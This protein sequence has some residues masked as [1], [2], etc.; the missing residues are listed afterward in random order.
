VIALRAQLEIANSRARKER[1]DAQLEIER[2]R[3]QF[4]QQMRGDV[5]SMKQELERE[6]RR[7]KEMERSLKQRDIELSTL[8]KRQHA[9]DALRV[10]ERMARSSVTLNASVLAAS[11]IAVA[12]SPQTNAS[13][14][15]GSPKTAKRGADNQRMARLF[16]GRS[17]RK[18]AAAAAAAQTLG[19]STSSVSAQ[20]AATS[21]PSTPATAAAQAAAVTSAA[22]AAVVSAASE[23]SGI[24]AT[25]FAENVKSFCAFFE[26]RVPTFPLNDDTYVLTDRL[27]AKTVQLVAVRDRVVLSLAR[28]RA[29][30]ASMVHAAI[31]MDEARIAIMGD[32]AELYKIDGHDAPRRLTP[33]L[34]RLVTSVHSDARMP[35]DLARAAQLFD[36]SESSL[37]FEL[38]ALFDRIRVR[39]AV[40]RTRNVPST[41]AA[42]LLGIDPT[43]LVRLQHSGSG[44]G[45]GGVS[46]GGAGGNVTGGGGGG[47]GDLVSMNSSGGSVVDSAPTASL[48]GSGS[49][50]GSSGGSG[51]G[52]AGDDLLGGVPLAEREDER[53]LMEDIDTFMTVFSDS[54]DGMMVDV[55]RVH[56]QL[57]SPAQQAIATPVLTRARAIMDYRPNIDAQQLP[58][59]PLTSLLR[60]PYGEQHFRWLLFTEQC[61]ESLLFWLDV[62]RVREL[63]VAGTDAA[64]MRANLVDIYRTYIVQGASY[65][66]NISSPVRRKLMMVFDAALRASLRQMRR[67]PRQASSDTP[68][69]RDESPSFARRPGRP[70]VTLDDTSPHSFASLN[71]FESADTEQSSGHAVRKTPSSDS[72]GGSSSDLFGALDDDIDDDDDD[73]DEQQ[74][75]R[76]PSHGIDDAAKSS[77]NEETLDDE[78]TSLDVSFLKQ[79]DRPPADAPPTA[80]SMPTDEEP[81]WLTKL[82]IASSQA[83]ITDDGDVKYPCQRCGRVF[84]LPARLA[85]HVCMA[86]AANETP[87]TTP[88]RPSAKAANSASAAA[89]VAAPA[90]VSAAAA[91]VHTGAGLDEPLVILER[92]TSAVSLQERAIPRAFV[93]R[94]TRLQGTPGVTI[95]RRRVRRNSKTGARPPARVGDSPLGASPVAAA[96]VAAAAAAAVTSA[97]PLVPAVVSSRSNSLSRFVVPDGRA[98]DMD[99][100]ALPSD[101]AIFDEAAEEMFQ[102]MNNT[103]KERF[104]NGVAGRNLYHRLRAFE[105]AANGGPLYLVPKARRCVR[106]IADVDVGASRKKVY[107]MLAAPSDENSVWVGCHDGA[108]SLVDVSSCKVMRQVHKHRKAILALEIVGTEVWSS[109]E[110]SMLYCWDR[111]SVSCTSEVACRHP[112]TCIAQV[113]RSTVWC[114]DLG[115]SVAIYGV[116]LTV[117]GVNR[118]QPVHFTVPH[119]TPTC[120]LVVRDSV[121]LGTDRGV[122]AIYAA[123]ATRSSAAT[124]VPSAIAMS[125][126]TA[127]TDSIAPPVLQGRELRGGGVRQQMYALVRVGDTILAAAKSPVINVWSLEGEFLRTIETSHAF[128]ILAICSLGQHFVTAGWDKRISVWDGKTF[129]HVHDV[130]TAHED[131]VTSLAFVPECRDAPLWSGSWDRSIRAWQFG[132]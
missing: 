46:S 41:K 93:S 26:Q 63:F 90:T 19:G 37:V 110:D 127:A 59:L 58:K 116:T 89:T 107:R 123:D 95:D 13:A 120:L 88:R 6:R 10:S 111:R 16:A 98:V 114:G 2:T 84:I 20:S 31:M 32:I 103:Y 44:S 130:P 101:P 34:A 76:L 27:H 86:P 125:T 11:G 129:E 72:E 124:A 73:D 100:A 23:P 87:M 55:A 14:A 66:I 119:G 56:A 69:T 82:A 42:L 49:S 117:Y 53:D 97:A 113:D 4:E 51:V 77:D 118:S 40:S 104:I 22:A 79:L 68:P 38:R 64:T 35:A 28:A 54:F 47:G 128:S 33:A 5:E 70:S 52:G 67:K 131:A 115:S 29:W 121:W 18:A 61:S 25:T 91:D 30:H 71:D 24:A 92:K 96:A 57:A 106:V 45:G 85:A 75:K 50:V 9:E 102:L 43:S 99:N 3:L 8:R 132:L 17:G 94:P 1:Q 80:P 48:G 62:Q 105:R 39:S 112:V 83:I 65:E 7:L 126:T 36:E 122:V 108:M 109:S 78:E 81:S 60:S 15:A 12:Q 21:S 74:L